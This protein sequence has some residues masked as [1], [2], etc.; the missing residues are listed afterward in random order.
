MPS[1]VQ[2]KTNSK[3]YNIPILNGDMESLS[4]RIT[5]SRDELRELNLQIS[6]VL[7]RINTDSNDLLVL[8]IQQ[9]GTF[10]EQVLGGNGGRD[11]DREE[12]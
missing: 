4:N 6:T 3:F 2:I 10:P 7:N 1:T 11:S 9:T 5:R 8:Y 12:V